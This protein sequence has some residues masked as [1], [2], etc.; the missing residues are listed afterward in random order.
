[1]KLKNYDI[2]IAILLIIAFVACVG[3]YEAYYEYK[4]PKIV[5]GMD[6]VKAMRCAD[7]DQQTICKVSRDQDGILVVEKNPIITEHQRL[8]L[9]NLQYPIHPVKRHKGPLQ[10]S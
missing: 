2:V 6:E 4:E 1:M 7:I 8:V 5:Y 3:A 9:L 10:G